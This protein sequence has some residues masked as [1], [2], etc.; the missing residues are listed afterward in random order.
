MSSGFSNTATGDKPADPYKAKNLDTDASAKEKIED[1]SHF[2]SACKYGMMTTRDAKSGNLVSRCMALAAK[3]SRPNTPQG[4]MSSFTRILT[5]SR[6]SCQETGGIDLLFYTNTESG[7]T[8]ELAADSHVNISF[9]NSSGEWAS[10][11][12]DATVETDRE[13]VRKHYSQDLKAW[14]GDLGD[15]KHDGGPDDPR[16]GIIRVR[17]N[18]AT[19]SVANKN[20]VSRAADIA[21]GAVTGKAPTIQKLR[22]ISEG[23]IELWRKAN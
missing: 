7:K 20:F 22:E 11:S 4:H 2:I 15:G 12:G 9:T 6:L 10:I 13:L 17:T 1:L 18:T 5:N 23:E 8:D 16:I 21:Q 3:V 14:V 19:Y